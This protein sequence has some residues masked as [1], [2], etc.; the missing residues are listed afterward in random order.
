LPSEALRCEHRVETMS[1]PTILIVDDDAL[2]RGAA[3][4]TLSDAGYRVLEADTP[5][6]AE[7][8]LAQQAC[9]LVLVDLEMTGN[10]KL[11]WLGRAA[12][13][14][15][16]VAFV[17]CTGH[18]SLESAMH[19]VRLPVRAY[20]VKP[21]DAATLTREVARVLSD[22]SPSLE[23]ALVASAQAWKLTARELEVL[24]ELAGGA[25]NKQIAAALDCSLRTVELHV[26]ALLRK[27]DAP[28]RTALLARLAAYG[29][30]A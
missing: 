22:C 13:E 6:A 15:T 25:A 20:L 23:H 3:A 17:L 21:V 4:V 19:A 30:R 14:R 8:V 16:S 1:G 18:P 9:A 26:S 12:G 27:A 7:R 5:E 29:S 28:S 10:R 2:F 11:E 24:R